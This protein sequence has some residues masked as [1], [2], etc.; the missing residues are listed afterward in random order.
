MTLQ[1]TNSDL[2]KNVNF[3]RVSDLI[4]SRPISVEL[5][6]GFFFWKGRSFKGDSDWKNAAPRRIA[7]GAAVD[8]APVSADGVF[9]LRPR[10]RLAFHRHPRAAVPPQGA[11][12]GPRR[13]RRRPPPN[14]RPRHPTDR[15]TNSLEN[16]GKQK[17]T[18]LKEKAKNTAT[19]SHTVC[20]FT[21]SK[22]KKQQ[23][24]RRVFLLQSLFYAETIHFS[25][26]GCGNQVGAPFLN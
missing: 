10:V 18:T 16:I 23:N 22:S 15:R 1:K 21:V 13:R 24:I 17:K 3:S 2:K 20:D 9:H 7:S 25:L 8:G 11:V 12:D 5:F 26:I 19:I 14:R 6:L 4:L